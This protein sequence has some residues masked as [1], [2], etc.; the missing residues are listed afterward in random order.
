MLTAAIAVV[1]LLLVVSVV[2]AV[3]VDRGPSIGDV[4]LGYEQAWDRLDFDALWTLAGVELRD[5]LNHADYIRVKSAAYAGRAELR[6]LAS[7]ISVEGLV[8]G[9]GYAAARTRVTLPDG[10]A[11]RN[12]IELAR[13]SGTWV[14]VG[15]RLA[16]D[17]SRT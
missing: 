11:V 8:K 15:Y 4:A 12:D 2:I 13:R 7:T 17:P 16:T 14:V 6:N 10:S 9:T 5:G 3:A 1:V